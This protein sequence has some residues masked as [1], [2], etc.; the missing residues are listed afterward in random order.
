MAQR[1]LVF[2]FDGTLANSFDAILQLANALA[3]EFGYRPARTDEIELLRASSYQAIATQLG[4]AWHK[5]PQIVVRMHSEL[6]RN[7][8]A[9]Q[10]FDG[11]PEVLSELESRGHVL[12]ILTSNSRENVERFLAARDLDHFDFIVSSPSVWGKENRLRTLLHRRGL[13][14]QD[15]LYVGDEVRDIEATRPL[16][17]G[18]IAVAW[19]FSAHAL[20]AAHAP[21][22]L[23]REPADLLT[24]PGL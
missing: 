18:M 11:L 19:G 24:I 8:N 20:L 10:T 12:G 15:V 7:M 23:V 2:D 21:D 1:T 16:Q 5:I 3:P 22:Y 13:R 6:R 9:L 14:P 4:I 17:V